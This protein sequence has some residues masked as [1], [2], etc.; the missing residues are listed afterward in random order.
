MKK[1]FE[2]LNEEELKSLNDNINKKL[3]DLTNKKKTPKYDT[4]VLAGCSSKGFVLLGAIDY[5]LDNY[6]LKNIKNMIGTSSGSIIMFLLAIGYTPIE[7]VENLFTDGVMDNLS[8]FSITKMVD[9]NGALSY[10]HVQTILEKMTINKIGYLPTLQNIKDRFGK[11]L[12]FTTYNLTK[13]KIEYMSYKNNPELPCL[14]AIRMSSSL[15]LIFE[16]FFYNNSFY[17]DGGVCDNFPL[18]KGEEIGEKVLGI[19]LDNYTTNYKPDSNILELMYNCLFIPVNENVKNSIQNKKES[20]KVVEL[21]LNTD[22]SFFD[23]KIDTTTKL[24]MF[25]NGYNQFKNQI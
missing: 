18:Q 2:I 23:F 14:T 20:T 19:T 7:M 25:S 10:S 24:D 8:S 15:P 21:S 5:S 4:L 12:I 6:I 13:S 17:L 16:R 9:N 1:V 3:L 11:N 22:I